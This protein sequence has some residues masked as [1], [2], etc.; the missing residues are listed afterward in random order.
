MLNVCYLGIINLSKSNFFQEKS[1]CTLLLT[2]V[3]SRNDFLCLLNGQDGHDSFFFFKLIL[4]N[5]VDIDDDESDG[6][7][8]RTVPFLS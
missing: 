2:F 7:E 8:M 6:S 1:V 5:G 3:G 4:C